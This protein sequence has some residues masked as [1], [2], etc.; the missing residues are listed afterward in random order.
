MFLLHTWNIVKIH[1]CIRV[2]CM[3]NNR[4]LMKS[5]S[6]RL[7][8]F[9]IFTRFGICGIIFLII[10]DS[11]FYV[12]CVCS[13]VIVNSLSHQQINFNDLFRIILNVLITRSYFFLFLLL[14]GWIFG[15][16][17][18][19]VHYQLCISSWPW[20]RKCQIQKDFFFFLLLASCQNNLFLYNSL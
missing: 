6:G 3:L 16:P 17:Y 1:M 19:V 15:G 2:N 7:K 8:L 5:F 10:Y 14:F 4:Y 11:F 18:N 9:K 12:S 20:K 13:Y